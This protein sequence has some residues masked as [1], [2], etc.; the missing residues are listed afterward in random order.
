MNKKQTTTKREF[1]I[2]IKNDVQN[3]F[4]SLNID[5]NQSNHN[6]KIIDKNYAFT[7]ICKNINDT[8]QKSLKMILNVY[9]KWIHLFREKKS[10]KFFFKHKSWNHEIKLKLK[11][12]FTF[13]FI[14]VLFEIEFNVFKKYLNT[15]LKKKF[16]KKFESSTKYSIFFTF[17]K[18]DKFRL[19]VDY[20]KLNNI[21]IKNKYLLF[22]IN[23][24]QNK[25]QKTKYFIK[26]NL[27]KIYNLIR[28]K[29]MKNNFQNSI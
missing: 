10:T 12:Q 26:I 11:K 16:I 28:I 7:K 19:C 14:Y 17:K 5:K 1:A 29:K 24:F 2:S 8:T 25:L 6:N 23:E 4:N 27:R 3:W 9:K 20:Q 22:S 21:T 18:N 13:E 15:N